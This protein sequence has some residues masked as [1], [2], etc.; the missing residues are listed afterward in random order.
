[1]DNK[2][3][4]GKERIGKLLV[5]LALPSILAQLINV[6]Y[7]IVDRLYI[8]GLKIDAAMSG[9]TVCFPILMIVSAFSALVGMGGAPLASI[10]L[11]RGDKEKA[12][13]FLNNSVVL[14]LII[15]VVLT[16]LVEALRPQILRLFGAT[17]SSMSYAMDYLTIY[18]AGTIFVQFALGLNSFISAQGFARTSM[19]SVVI[20]AVTNIVLDPIFIFAFKM[21]IKG[22]ALATIISQAVSAIWIILFLTGKKTILRIS[23]KKMG[24]SPKIVFPILALGVS[25]FIMQATESFVQ[26]TFNNGFN[27]YS[28]SAAEADI[29]IAGMGVLFTVMQMTNM[30]LIGLAQGAQP[31][32][33]YNYGAGQMDRV[34]KAYKLLLITSAI[35][36]FT[37]WTLVMA[38]P[39]IFARPFATSNEVYE[40]AEYGLRIFMAGALIF[41]LQ[42][43]CQQSMVALGQAKV[44]LFLA[45]FRKVIMLIPLA[46]VL[47]MLMEDK[48]LALLI[49]EPIAD[50]I[51]ATVTTITF[52]IVFR[53]LCAKKQGESESISE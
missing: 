30:P 52:F 16:A 10:E 46:T 6:L 28:A 14:L 38:V 19:L 17:D 44:S 29:A 1:M 40:F 41:C 23:F 49:S 48:T 18:M 39:G 21:G 45:L 2:E 43:S 26:M 24:L 20:G 47:P 34:K 25:P 9:L 36:C 35:F 5:K 11:G 13:K 31:I 33:S 22:A 32:I 53:H 27:K 8:A 3:M 15:S 50:V 37:V 12:E 4:L 42:F 7:N 51:A